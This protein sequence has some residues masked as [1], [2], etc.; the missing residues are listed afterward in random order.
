[1]ST[2]AINIFDVSAMKLTDPTTD[3]RCRHIAADTRPCSSRAL[4]ALRR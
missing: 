1:M 4:L 2:I 3:D